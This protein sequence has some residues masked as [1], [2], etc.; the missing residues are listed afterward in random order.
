MLQEEHSAILS[1]FIKLPSVIKIFVLSIL[2]GRLR[3]VL[4]YLSFFRFLFNVD[5]DGLVFLVH[6]HP[7]DEHEILSLKKVLA[8]TLSARVQVRSKENCH[9]QMTDQS[10]QPVSQVKV[11]FRLTYMY[12]TFVT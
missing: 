6:H 2:N 8:S 5:V 7:E 9:L 10:V 4:L 3:Q 1:T 11:V 12:Y